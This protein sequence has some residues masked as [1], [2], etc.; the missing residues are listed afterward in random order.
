MCYSHCSAIVMIVT[1]K[2][3]VQSCSAGPRRRCFDNLLEMT[4]AT[5][6]QG[7]PVIWM[8]LM[9]KASPPHRAALWGYFVPWLLSLAFLGFLGIL[10][11]FPGLSRGRTPLIAWGVWHNSY[12]R[13][14]L[15]S[16]REGHHSLHLEPDIPHIPECSFVPFL[17]AVKHC[18]EKLPCLRWP[19]MAL[20]A[21]RGP[22]GCQQAELWPSLSRCLEMS[23][24]NATVKAV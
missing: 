12:S 8:R 21:Y 11:L 4:E 14:S 1:G 22:R 6:F 16:H 17:W 3:A 23:W 15:D 20:D 24:W 2:C 5:S 10:E 7:E 9:L 18:S 19:V 13:S